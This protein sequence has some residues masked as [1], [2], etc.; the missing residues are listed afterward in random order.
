MQAER[1]VCFDR[2]GAFNRLNRFPS[3]CRYRPF[4]STY[5]NTA[6]APL[7][8]TVTGEAMGD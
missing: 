5:C 2:E 1:M 3:E 7:R 4:C 6:D 8:I